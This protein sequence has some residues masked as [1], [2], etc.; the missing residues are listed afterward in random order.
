LPE[1]PAFPGSPVD[2]QG[3]ASGR[4]RQGPH[5]RVLVVG[6]GDAKAMINH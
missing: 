6:K 3:I 2:Q 5:Q 1:V 4:C